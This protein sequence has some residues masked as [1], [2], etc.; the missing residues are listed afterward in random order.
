MSKILWRLTEDL[1]KFELST[2]REDANTPP[3]GKHAYPILDKH[4]PICPQSTNSPYSPNQTPSVSL[5]HQ[6][7]PTCPRPYPS[8]L[9]NLPRI[10]SLGLLWKIQQGKMFWVARKEHSLLNN[11]KMSYQRK[12]AWFP[13]MMKT[14]HR[15]WWRLESNTTRNNEF[16]SLKLS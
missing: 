16:D 15:Y 11:T 2:K 1:R 14:T 8:Q 7:L 13:K 12:G 9:P 10:A 3:T 4:I 5:P 6:I